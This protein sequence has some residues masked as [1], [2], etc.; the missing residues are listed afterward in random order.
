MHTVKFDIFSKKIV[1]VYK[2]LFR[3]Y[4]ARVPRHFEINIQR[5]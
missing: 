2:N 5:V 4:Y 3:K 1:D